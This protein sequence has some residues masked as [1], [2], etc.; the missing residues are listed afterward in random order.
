V[1]IKEKQASKLNQGD[2]FYHG[3]KTYR[4]IGLLPNNKPQVL[5]ML[6]V[7]T[8]DPEEPL[9]FRIG[10]QSKVQMKSNVFVETAAMCWGVW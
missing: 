10:A 2:V 6:I 5:S 1:L 8:D 3:P 7:A 4:F 9:L